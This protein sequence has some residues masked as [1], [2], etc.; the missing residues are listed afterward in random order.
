MTTLQATDR[1]EIW[2]PRWLGGVSASSSFGP[3]LLW[4]EDLKATTGF[5]HGRL[6]THP[7]VDRSFSDVFWGMTEVSRT[8]IQLDNADNV[9]DAI[10]TGAPGGKTLTLR[11]Y[12]RQAGTVAVE[13]TGVIDDA[14][15]S[16]GVIEL[17]AVSPDLSVFEQ[18][19][20]RGTVT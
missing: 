18:L 12:D 7:V 11:R 14:I 13:F 4:T 2:E 1:Q 17:S 5:Y 3:R 9:L 16:P 10:Y 19:I 8:V 15:W 20:P 6:M